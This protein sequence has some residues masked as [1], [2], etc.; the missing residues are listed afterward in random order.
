MKSYVLATLILGALTATSC[1]DPKSAAAAYLATNPGV[2]EGAAEAENENEGAAD[3]TPASELNFANVQAKVLSKCV[4]CHR[5]DKASSGVDIDSYEK[6]KAALNGI[7]NAATPDGASMP[8]AGALP[9][10]QRKL[11]LDWINAGAPEES[12]AE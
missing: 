10:D 7:R 11:L 4:S 8:P 2:S 5:V 1:S 3:T 12:P 9:A 6:V